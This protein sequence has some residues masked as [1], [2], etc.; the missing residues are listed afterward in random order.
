MDSKSFY[1]GHLVVFLPKKSNQFL[2]SPIY[3]AFV[4]IGVGIM[5]AIRTDIRNE[6]LVDGSVVRV[7]QDYSA[8]NSQGWL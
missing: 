3:K 8:E 2:F 5:E 4:H 1:I 7:G 6:A